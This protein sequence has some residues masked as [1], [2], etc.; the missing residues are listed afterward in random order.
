MP[1]AP[2][3]Y[4]VVLDPSHGG[5]DRGAALTAEIAEKDVTLTFARYLRQ[6]LDARGLTTLLLRDGDSTLSLDQRASLTNSAHPAIY[7]CV[8]AASQG[9]GV[10]FYTALVPG[11]GEDRGPFLGWDTAQAQFQS[12]SRIAATALTKQVQS[13]QISGRVLREQRRREQHHRCALAI[14]VAPPAEDASQLSS[15]AYL[16]PLAATTAAGIADVRDKLEA[17]R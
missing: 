10:R 4:F 1:S 15:A 2:R 7:L 16:Q 6:E 11:E 17:G 8:H 5:D 13:K 14:E 12:L 3:R 9:N